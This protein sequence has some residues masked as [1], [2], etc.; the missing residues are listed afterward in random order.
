MPNPLRLDALEAPDEP[1][2]CG[3]GELVCSPTCSAP[4]WTALEEATDDENGS[5]KR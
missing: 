1:N 4:K 5:A 2:C 3:A